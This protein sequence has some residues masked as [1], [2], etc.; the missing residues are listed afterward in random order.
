MGYLDDNGLLYLWQKITSKFVGKELK[1]GSSTVYKVLSDNNLTDELVTK[2][3]NA[4]DSSFSGNY[5]DLTGKPT[6]LSGINATEGSKLEGIS[7]GAQVNVIES[8]KVNGTAQSIS[9]KAVNITV[10]TDNKNLTNGAGYQTASQVQT[11][12]TSYGY[13]TSSQVQT[14]IN[15]ALAG[16]TGISFEVVASLPSTGV[17][18]VIYLVSNSGSNPNSYDEYIWVNNKFEKI[19]TT[20]V[21]LSGY[22]LTSSTISNATIDTLLA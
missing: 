12:I 19:G 22:M 14:A 8:I 13:Q 6:S 5:S 17:V 11:A 15:N 4:G 2:I 1:T 18:G 20:D 10:P 7:A 3:Q 16:I 9:G 21:D